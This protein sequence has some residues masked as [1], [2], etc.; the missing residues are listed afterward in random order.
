MPKKSY[1]KP[2][3]AFLLNLLQ[4]RERSGLSQEEAGRRLGRNQSYVSRCESGRRMITVAEM[5]ELADLYGV[6]IQDLLD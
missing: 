1:D 6:S 5:F 4:A 3:K 2:Y